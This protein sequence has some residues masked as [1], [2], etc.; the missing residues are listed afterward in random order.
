M[1]SGFMSFMMVFAAVMAYRA[2]GGAGLVA[3][4]AHVKAG[5]PRNARRSDPAALGFCGDMTG[6]APRVSSGALRRL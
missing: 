2:H 5:P 1:F 6:K 4:L 3:A